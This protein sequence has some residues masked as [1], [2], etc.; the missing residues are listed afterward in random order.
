MH[1]G[2]IHSNIPMGATAFDAVRYAEITWAGRS[3]IIII[4][5]DYNTLVENW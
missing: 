1:Y 5:L 2:T 4:L 3:N